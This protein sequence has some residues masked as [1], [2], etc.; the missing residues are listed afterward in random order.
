MTRSDHMK[1]C[2]ERAW[3]S[4]NYKKTKDPVGARTDAIASMISDIGKHE[5]TAPMVMMAG[6][7][8]MTV[9][10]ESSLRR[11]IDGFAE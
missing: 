5:D 1:W 11:F 7:L 6:M 9:T 8:M 2:K 4:Y 3:Q 10:D